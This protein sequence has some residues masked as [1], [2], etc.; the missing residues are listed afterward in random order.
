MPFSDR[1]T[2]SWISRTYLFDHFI[3][4]QVKLGVDMVINLGA[5]L[6]ARPFRMALPASLLWIEVD[7]PGILK[8]KEDV[9][10]VEKP[11]CSL[12]RIALD[13]SD[14]E[15]R[16]DLFKQ[17]GD[18]ANNAL[19]ITE[20]LLI[21][22]TD[23]EVGQLALDLAAVKS[24]QRWILDLS[25]PGLVRMLQKRLG[26]QLS[27]GGSSLKF[28]PKQGPDFFLPYGWKLVEVRSLL[29]T[30]ASLKRLPFMMRLVA[31]MPESS[32]EQGSRPWSGVCLLT[33]R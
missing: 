29:K 15:K 3:K 9:L 2:W 17:L 22:L 14:R 19:I 1:H 11:V 28:G 10:A 33:K 8:Y 26:K 7:L 31:L 27:Q 23:E 25:S 21:Y 12:E 24:F 5:G 16:Q 32:G 30:A 13:L 6:D 4:E 20:G 18:R